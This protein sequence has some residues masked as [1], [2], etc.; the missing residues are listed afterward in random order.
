MKRGVRVEGIVANPGY[1]IVKFHMM[2]NIIN[3]RVGKVHGW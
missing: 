1:H 3:E 2:M